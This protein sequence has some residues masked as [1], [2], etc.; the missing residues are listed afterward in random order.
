MPTGNAEPKLQA[1]LIGTDLAF[2]ARTS[3]E[4]A[5]E[6]TAAMRCPYRLS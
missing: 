4:L 1:P 3:L 2:A 6:V 5:A